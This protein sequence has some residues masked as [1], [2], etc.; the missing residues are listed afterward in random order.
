MTHDTNPLDER[1]PEA[2]EADTTE[3]A[4]PVRPDDDRDDRVRTGPEVPEADAVEQARTVGTDD[5]YRP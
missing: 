5:E 3:Q 1:H 2:T 4:I